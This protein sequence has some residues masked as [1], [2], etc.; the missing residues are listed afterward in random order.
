MIV[1][2]FIIFHHIYTAEHSEYSTFPTYDLISDFVRKHRRAEIRDFE[3][4]LAPD[5]LH[6]NIL[7]REVAMNNAIMLMKVHESTKQLKGEQ[8]A[9]LL[10]LK[11]DTSGHDP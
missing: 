6:Q 5:L 9:K 10:D 4:K 2:V 3:K 1:D 8:L 11:K 7:R